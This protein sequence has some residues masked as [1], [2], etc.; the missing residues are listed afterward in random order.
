MEKKIIVLP[1]DVNK[2]GLFNDLYYLK[3]DLLNVGF[4]SKALKEIT[5]EEK[6]FLKSGNGIIFNCEMNPFSSNKEIY[7]SQK[8]SWLTDRFFESEDF[9]LIFNYKIND[10]ESSEDSLT[11]K[12]S[13]E[14]FNFL[15]NTNDKQI[16]KLAKSINAF[17]ESKPD[18]NYS[19]SVIQKTIKD[20]INYHKQ[21]DENSNKEVISAFK[22]NKI[23]EIYYQTK[24]QDGKVVTVNVYLNRN[25]LW[26]EKT[27][28]KS[29]IA[30][31]NLNLTDDSFV[32]Y[33]KMGN[34]KK[35]NCLLIFFY[36]V[37]AAKTVNSCR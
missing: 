36:L 35:V 2:K 13:R 25:T 18:F 26:Y 12:M 3:N 7:D 21:D 28:T 29:A 19:D 6:N 20:E 16:N 11:L 27:T 33:K 4:S 34:G 22:K 9:N 30:E 23:T 24:C 10:Q 17:M 8:K 31:T 15:K 14:A 1:L 32:V 5:R 37:L